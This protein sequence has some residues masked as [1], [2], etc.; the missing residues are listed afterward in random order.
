MSTFV[1]TSSFINSAAPLSLFSKVRSTFAGKF[2]G[3]KFVFKIF[4]E[5]VFLMLL[6]IFVDIRS[7][8]F[9]SICKNTLAVL[10]GLILSTS[11]ISNIALS[12]DE[13]NTSD[14]GDGGDDLEDAVNDEDVV[15]TVFN[16]I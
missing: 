11:F 1:T 13:S 12:L 8:C 16:D 3:S 5:S 2:A 10:S 4:S 6:L 14:R 7:S 9:S 15:V